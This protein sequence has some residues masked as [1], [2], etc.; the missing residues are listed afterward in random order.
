MNRLEGRHDAKAL[1]V[2][3]AYVQTGLALVSTDSV[4]ELRNIKIRKRSLI[5]DFNAFMARYKE[6]SEIFSAAQV[7]FIEVPT[8]GYLGALY[9]RRR[10]RIETIERL[11]LALLCF[12]IA[13]Q[14]LGYDGE[15]Y[16]IGPG[17]LAQ[18]YK[19]FVIDSDTGKQLR[20]LKLKGA[21][22]VRRA[23]LCLVTPNHDWMNPEITDHESDAAF[24]GL[25]A[26]QVWKMGR[27]DSIV[28][29][30]R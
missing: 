29:R 18:A 5:K 11:T 13:L 17:K 16:Y 1:G 27:I 10:T 25:A 2:D 19:G 3:L 14:E 4:I 7:I 20:A 22:L 6:C 12:E 30:Q 24:I 8:T 21:K 28:S 23:W 9:K 26:L 15:V